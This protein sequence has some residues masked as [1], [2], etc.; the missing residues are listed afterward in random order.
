MRAAEG[1]NEDGGRDGD[2]EVSGLGG[3][4]WFG[5][6][7]VGYEPVEEGCVIAGTALEREGEDGSDEVCGCAVCEF[8]GN[9]S[10]FQDALGEGGDFDVEGSEDGGGVAGVGG[11]CFVVFCAG[12]EGGD[13]AKGFSRNNFEGVGFWAGGLEGW[14]G[15]GEALVGEMGDGAFK[16]EGGVVR[17]GLEEVGGEGDATGEIGVWTGGL[18]VLLQWL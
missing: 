6:G 13:G 12:G 11:R 1:G 2:F 10:E 9:G 8:E 18:F 15:S 16:F 5:E 7:V 3:G 17:E 14:E 4:G